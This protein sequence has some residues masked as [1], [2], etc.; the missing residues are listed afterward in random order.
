M[1]RSY[2]DPETTKRK[3]FLA[4]ACETRRR[5]LLTYGDGATKEKVWDLTQALA[6]FYRSMPDTYL[7]YTAVPHFRDVLQTILDNPTHRYPAR[8][9]MSPDV[10]RAA[11]PFGPPT[12]PCIRMS[13]SLHESARNSLLELEDMGQTLLGISWAQIGQVV[14]AH[15][16]VQVHDDARDDGVD[17]YDLV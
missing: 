12:A 11:I 8:I 2:S 17:E 14:F 15:F 7:E 10:R 1:L 16:V 9:S 13:R 6:I 3:A 5:L 4:F